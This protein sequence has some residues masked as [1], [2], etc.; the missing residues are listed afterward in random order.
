M[1]DNTNLRPFVSPAENPLRVAILGSTGSVG[2]QAIDALTT[3]GCRIVM[4]AAG[5]DAKTVAEQARLYKPAICTMDS[6]AAAADLRLALAGVNVSVYGGTD[7]VCRGI[8]ECGADLIIHSIAGLAGL[9]S[10]IAA[11]KTGARIGMANKEAIITAGNWIYD[12]LKKSGGQLIPVDS[13]HSAIF[14]CLAAS[15]AARADG[16]D[17]SSIVKRILLTASGG[18][19]FGWDR[20]RLEGVTPETALAHPT[21]KMGPKITVDCAT[22]MNKGFE[23]IEAVRLFGVSVDQVD[24]LVHRQSIIHSMVEYIDNTVIAQ[25]GAPDMR[26]CIR[27]AASYPT[28]AWV[29]SEGLNFAAL[30]S[31]TFDAPDTETFP[32]LDVARNAIRRDG[33]APTALVAADEEA[34]DAFLKGH[35]SLNTMADAVMETMERTV[36]SIPTCLEDIYEA[37]SAAREMARNILKKYTR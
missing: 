33:I 13:E 27:Y 28:R 36:D 8:A 32:L 3:M 21:W 10:A 25:L 11:A 29:D 19:F 16:C 20:E 37:E 5:R 24:V 6:E 35:I 18:P 12:E 7:A 26:S 14:Q 23:V 1:M 30:H 17:G 15:G 4:L 34:V 9:P 22:L 31:L 2:K